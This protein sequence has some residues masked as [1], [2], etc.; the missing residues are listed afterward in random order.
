MGALRDE[1]DAC[2]RT[3]HPRMAEA[4]EADRV[5]HDEWKKGSE[6]LGWRKYKLTD[7]YG[8]TLDRFRTLTDGLARTVADAIP[9][10]QAGERPGILLLLAFLSFPGR[11][12]RSGYTKATIARALKKVSLED[13]AKTLLRE[14]LIASFTWAGPEFKVL[15]GWIPRLL[16]PE[17]RAQIQALSASEDPKTR[18]RAERVMDLLIFRG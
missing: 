7:R 8:T 10:A 13:E 3:L 11:F 14:I 2:T 6:E 9:K 17:F 15:R 18:R 16:T 4:Q 12:F 5:F 1:Y